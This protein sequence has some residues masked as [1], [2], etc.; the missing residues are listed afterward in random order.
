MIAVDQPRSFGGMTAAVAFLLVLFSLLLLTASG[1]QAQ[2]GSTSP[3]PPLQW[4]VQAGPNTPTDFPIGV[5][6]QQV[7][8]GANGELCKLL[9]KEAGQPIPT[10]FTWSMCPPAFQAKVNAREGTVSWASGAKPTECGTNCV[11]RPFVTQSQFLDRPNAIF[12]MLFGHLDFAIDVPGPFNRDVRFG[13][14]AQFRCVMKPGAREGDLDVRVAF[15]TPV[16]SDPGILESIT[17]FMVPANISRAIEQ[18]IRDRLATPGSQSQSLGRCRSIGANQAPQ[19][20]F[21]SILFDLPAMGTRQPT[22]R[23]PVA[24]L[25][26]SA[27]VRFLRITRKPVVGFSPPAEPGQFTVFLNGIPAQFPDTPALVLP[28]TGGSAAINSARLST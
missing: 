25:S 21:D 13:Y 6:R 1:A 24:A 2:E 26:S 15:G 16:I 3:P 10:N 5:L 22:V 4:P 23:V 7:E 28:V 8:F 20:A 17:G 11:G 14:E 18:G 27:T 19:P 12:A 9:L